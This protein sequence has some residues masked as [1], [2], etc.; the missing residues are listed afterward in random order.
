MQY[1]RYSSPLGMITIAGENSVIRGL[2]F[3]GQKYYPSDIPEYSDDIAESLALACRWLDAYFAGNM[4]PTDTLPLAP[5]G[6]TYQRLVWSCLQRIPYGQTVT[7]GQ[8]AAE[9]A[10]KLGV[11]SMSAQAIG[12]AVGRNPIS[13]IIPCHRVIGANGSLTGYAGGIER[14]QWLLRHEGIDIPVCDKK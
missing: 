3:E 14:K 7:Y 6:S 1:C 8:L 12:G 13:V 9:V 10:A 5:V 4:P 2:W 11:K